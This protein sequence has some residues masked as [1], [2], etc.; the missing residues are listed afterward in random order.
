MP[1]SLGRALAGLDAGWVLA[2]AVLLAVTAATTTTAGLLAMVGT[3]VVVA[4]LGLLQ[5]QAST[6]RPVGAEPSRAVRH[7]G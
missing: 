5:W 1:T 2:T 3:T 6:A 4:L 7:A